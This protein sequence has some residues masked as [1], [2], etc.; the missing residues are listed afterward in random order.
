MFYDNGCN[1][2]FFAAPT[3]PGVY[4][5]TLSYEENLASLY[6][7]FEDLTK[8][9]NDSF[10]NIK[11]MNTFD[12]KQIKEYVDSEI[13]KMYNVIEE[14]QKNLEKELSESL[15]DMETDIKKLSIKIER[16][17]SYLEDEILKVRS[18]VDK[19]Y[20]DI[21]DKTQE[22]TDVEV[23]KE[24]IKRRA[25][26]KGIGDRIDSIAKEYPN[27]YNPVFGKSTD[28]QD[29]INSLYEYLRVL[30]V[31]AI[32][33]D[34][35]EMTAEEYDDLSLQA[36]TFDIYSGYL[37]SEELSK[38]FS[39]F[40]GKKE[41]VKDVI[42]QIVDKLRWNA[43]TAKGFYTDSQIRGLTAGTLLW[44]A[45]DY[46]FLNVPNVGNDDD[47]GVNINRK[48]ADTVITSKSEIAHFYDTEQGMVTQD[49]RND[50]VLSKYVEDDKI[51]IIGYEITY[52]EADQL[53]LTTVLVS[54]ANKKAGNAN[55]EVRLQYND[56]NITGIYDYHR[57]VRI[58]NNG[59]RGND[60]NNVVTIHSCE[61][62]KYD[63]TNVSSEI[64]NDGLI[65]K[66]ISAIYETDAIENIDS[67][68]FN[69]R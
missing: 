34:S 68:L 46:E 43:N 53:K 12:V 61:L 67:I 66:S 51:R 19:T 47:Y 39:P 14:I 21:F 64:V 49:I 29:C 17:V 36:F 4:N 48:T 62:T 11:N 26:D 57:L 18:Y 25:A 20:K 32:D 30:G 58:E 2:P 28:L 40:T 38:I 42:S 65:V 63:Y 3:I 44:S 9:V 33:Y 27:V 69:R 35:L 59:I 50:S 8:F 7:H 13:K 22:Y 37:F 15:G 45:K 31:N 24:A 10:T 54:D 16:E 6:K 5:D 23:E 1:I 52:L 55:A 56:T 41:S 60:P